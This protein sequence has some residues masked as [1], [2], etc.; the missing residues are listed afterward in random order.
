MNHLNF[1]PNNF[2]AVI[3][4]IASVYSMADKIFSKF[5]GFRFYFN[6]NNI[7]NFIQDGIFA[8]FRDFR[9]TEMEWSTEIKTL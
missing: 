6:I 7:F 4:R 2:D 8:N 9:V 3:S 1:S 5:S